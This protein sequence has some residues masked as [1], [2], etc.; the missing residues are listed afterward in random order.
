VID[1][2]EVIQDNPVQ[3]DTSTDNVIISQDDQI[4]VISVPD[5][6]P[7]GPQGPPGLQGPV[8]ATGLQGPTGPVG[9]TGPQGAAGAGLALVSDTAP[10]GQPD[11]ALWYESDSG[12][13]FVRYNDG[14]ST[15]WVQVV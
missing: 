15:Q 14:T 8:G 13:L 7:A 10:T 5:Q 4:Q 6:G 9:P 12:L 3:T 1:I 11:N 2:P